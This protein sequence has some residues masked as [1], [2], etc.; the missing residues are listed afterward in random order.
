MN[1]TEVIKA[2]MKDTKATQDDLA[3]QIGATSQSVISQRIRY[4]TIGIVPL[5]E[6]LDALGYE[7]VVRES[8]GE[9]QPGEYPIRL[10]DYEKG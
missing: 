7:I 10:V 9:Y 1:H 5:L 3:R 4:K 6:M 8:Y 2:I